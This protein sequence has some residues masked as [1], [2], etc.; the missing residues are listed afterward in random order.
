M[1][2]IKSLFF[3]LAVI[4]LLLSCNNDDSIPVT[5]VDVYVAGQ[6][7]HNGVWVPA[8]WK[9]GQSNNLSDKEGN[10]T[11]VLVVGTDVYFGGS[12]E[13]D[14]AIWKNGSLIKLTE[15]S[16]A[17]FVKS[18]QA[19]GSGIRV[20][21]FSVGAGGAHQFN[22]Y[23]GTSSTVLDGVAN[24]GYQPMAVV[25]S[26]VYIIMNEY[27][28]DLGNHYPT[29]WKNGNKSIINTPYAEAYCIAVSGTDVYVGG[30]S[31]NENNKYVATLWKNG[32]P[33]LLSAAGSA[34][35]NIKIEDAN[36]YA[37]GYET[38]TVG[39]DVAVYWKNGQKFTVSDGTKNT[40]GYQLEIKNTDIY[41]V[42]E[43]HDGDWYTGVWKNGSRVAPFL[44]NDVD[45]YVS[46]IAIH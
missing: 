14:A 39:K 5:P 6:H 33:V 7:I 37:L 26:D 19:N 3:F 11:A 38:N 24:V 22:L 41:V 36:V 15:G 1:K 34:I 29:V 44:G 4:V 17:A 16:S 25:G 12:I 46:G 21:Y 32:E 30:T 23:N 8:F 45:K 2:K 28:H 35:Y 13:N 40:Y 20:L 43:Y 10:A 31:K 9:N 42:G 18:I 27:S